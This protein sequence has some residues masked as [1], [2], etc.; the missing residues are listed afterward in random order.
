MS[1]HN[2]WLDIIHK[3]SMSVTSIFMFYAETFEEEPEL[4]RDSNS[5]PLNRHQTICLATVKVVKGKTIK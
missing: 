2:Q 3:G 1:K 4:I 5:P